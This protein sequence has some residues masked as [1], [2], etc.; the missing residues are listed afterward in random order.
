MRGLAH[1]SAA[2]SACLAPSTT[3]TNI[4]TVQV[5]STLVACYNL[6]QAALLVKSTNNGNAT[7]SLESFTHSTCPSKLTTFF[8][9][10]SAKKFGYTQVSTSGHHTARR[11]VPKQQHTLLQRHA[12]VMVAVANNAV[13]TVVDAPAHATCTCFFARASICLY[14]WPVTFWVWSRS[15]HK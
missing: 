8:M 7:S 14:A 1:A 10:S 15:L 12:V 13:A 4:T 3:T 11:Q 9:S 6:M 2:P 5:R